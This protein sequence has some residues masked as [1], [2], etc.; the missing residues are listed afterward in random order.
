MTN[1]QKR[2]AALLFI[3]VNM[4]GITKCSRVGGGYL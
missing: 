1:Q 3:S 2:F 4:A